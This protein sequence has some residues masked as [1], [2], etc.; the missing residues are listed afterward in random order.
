LF[1]SGNSTLDLSGYYLANNYTN[2]TQWQFPPGT[3][4]GPGSFRIVWLDG[5]PAQ[6]SGA[7]LH[8]NFRAN[9]ITGSVALVRF[10]EG[11][12]Q[13][14]DYLNYPVIGPDLSYG[15]APDG[16][17]FNRTILFSPTPGASNSFRTVNVF[18]NEWMAANTN[19]AP[20]DPADGTEDWFELYNAGTEAIDLGGYWLTDNLN[21]TWV[22]RSY[23]RPA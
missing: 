17:P 12:P 2:L 6:T 7:N 9:S 14:T 11:K 20:A 22:T 1:N 4:L 16:Q 13:I 8:A 18:I 21:N 19:T 10:A 23:Q 3:T 5:E 15:S